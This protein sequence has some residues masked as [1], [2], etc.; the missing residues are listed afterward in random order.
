MV[1]GR[2]FGE[3]FGTNVVENGGWKNHRKRTQKR[4]RRLGGL[5][6]RRGSAEGGEASPRS[7]ARSLHYHLARPATSDEVRRI[8]RLPPLPPTSH[9]FSN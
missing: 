7:F 9:D 4:E 1:F 5:R 8:Y 3:C 2:P 6:Q